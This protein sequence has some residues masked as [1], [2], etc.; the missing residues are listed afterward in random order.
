VFVAAQVLGAI[1]AVAT[2]G[3]LLRTVRD[4]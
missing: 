1:F 3:W 4:T 2:F